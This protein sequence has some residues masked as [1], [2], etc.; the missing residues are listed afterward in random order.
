MTSFVLQE[1][2]EGDGMVKPAYLLECNCG[3]DVF[4]VSMT[5]IATAMPSH[6]HYQCSQCEQTYCTT[7][8]C[9]IQLVDQSPR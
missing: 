9:Q 4:F 8:Q 3:G 2:D 1:V 7:G 5:A 6:L